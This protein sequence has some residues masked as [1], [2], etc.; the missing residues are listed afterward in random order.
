MGLEMSSASPN[1]AVS[2]IPHRIS[3]FLAPVE[4]YVFVSNVVETPLGCID[5]MRETTGEKNE[6]IVKTIYA[7]IGQY[8]AAFKLLSEVEALSLSFYPTFLPF[9]GFTP[10]NSYR[11]RRPAIVYEKYM[12]DTLA[13]CL[14][15]ESMEQIPINWTVTSKVRAAIGVA[16]SLSHIHSYGYAHGALIPEN[17]V[18]GND[19]WPYLTD[20]GFQK[21]FDSEH[22]DCAIT[23]ESMIWRAPEISDSSLST[24]QGDIYSFGY[25]LFQLFAGKKAY[26]AISQN[27]SLTS[28]I[29][30]GERPKIPPSVPNEI[31]DLIHRCWSHSPTSRPSAKEIVDVLGNVVGG[32]SGVS[33]PTM[34]KF[35]Q[36]LSTQNAEIEKA[37]I[38]RLAAD[39]GDANAQNNYGV[40]L[41]NGRGVKKNVYAAALYF[42]LSAN[43]GCSEGEHNC[44]FALEHGTG[45]PKN[46]S[47]A[48]HFYKSAADR[49]FKNS[50]LSYAQLLYLGEGIPRDYSEAAKYFRLAAQ[51]DSAPAQYRL[52]LL[53]ELGNGVEKNSQE[54][55]KCFRAAS[56]QKYPPA[57][58]R[59]GT[60][61]VAGFGVEV[62]RVE[63]FRNITIAAQNGH[64]R[65][66]CMLGAMS[67][68]GEGAAKKLEE[69]QRLFESAIS[70]GDGAGAIGLSWIASI[71]HNISEARTQILRGA[72]LGTTES[73]KIAYFYLKDGIGGSNDVE[74]SEKYKAASESP[75]SP[76]MLLFFDILL[77]G[78]NISKNTDGMISYIKDLTKK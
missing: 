29:S 22:H 26:D 24:K 43:Q 75:D 16:T 57:L 51:Q 27:E 54:A 49:G 50:Q 5:I 19:F 73:Q 8:K 34:E 6:V 45:V 25:I 55:F 68:N 67:L 23:M 59:Y 71:N 74:A 77:K 56:S 28:R 12:G 44:G 65:A 70:K 36:Q 35:R 2:A 18:F 9:I 42:R 58:Y 64:A 3:A 72:E 47:L 32:I 17:I 62:N 14:K 10:S 66:M 1:G 53:Y 13:F 40:M 52:G 15:M 76:D 7:D 61:L 48:A 46:K 33:I 60:S 69:A 37:R 63:G 39:N 4:S 41:L 20:L 11:G 78:T 38:C 21:Y 30:I 31:R